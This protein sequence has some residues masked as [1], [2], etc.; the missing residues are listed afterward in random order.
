MASRI[1]AAAFL[2]ISHA[3]IWKKYKTFTHAK[4]VLFGRWPSQAMRQMFVAYQNFAPSA[5]FFRLAENERLLKLN[6]IGKKMR[7]GVA[8]QAK[9]TFGRV[10]TMKQLRNVRNGGHR[11]ASRQSTH[12]CVRGFNGLRSSADGILMRLDSLCT[13]P[14]FVKIANV[15][16]FRNIRRYQLI[17]LCLLGFPRIRERDR[18]IMP[19]LHKD[20]SYPFLIPRICLG[21]CATTIR[22][23]KC[24][25]FCNTKHSFGEKRGANQSSRL[26]WG[27]CFQNGYPRTQISSIKQHQRIGTVLSQ[28]KELIMGNLKE[29]FLWFARDLL[30]FPDDFLCRR[31]S[32]SSICN[33]RGSFQAAL[34]GPLET[35]G[36]ITVHHCHVLACF[37]QAQPMKCVLSNRTIERSTCCLRKSLPSTSHNGRVFDSLGSIGLHCRKICLYSAGTQQLSP[38]A[39]HLLRSLIYITEHFYHPLSQ[40]PLSL[41]TPPLFTSPPPNSLDT[42]DRPK[43]SFILALRIKLFSLQADH[44]DQSPSLIESV[45][46]CYPSLLETANQ[47]HSLKAL[48]PASTQPFFSSVQP[49]TALRYLMWGEPVE[50]SPEDAVE[51]AFNLGG[52]ASALVTDCTSHIIHESRLND[53]FDAVFY[54]SRYFIPLCCM[55]PPAI[56]KLVARHPHQESEGLDEFTLHGWSFPATFTTGHRSYSPKHIV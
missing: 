39:Q 16:C 2:R 40:H 10:N 18:L 30:R 49:L 32:R 53:H 41:L 52:S 50:G 37:H 7:Q 29:H 35:G 24:R 27:A 1:E 25:A 45:P 55:S 54:S 33:R 38:E 36:G 17:C 23:D 44:H 56:W 21:I 20:S 46:I 34:T 5:F 3:L 51:E 26:C 12:C 11:V 22:V 14:F 47:T 31:K 13:T 19:T 48:M 42:K 43:F 9:V 28:H 8:P 6:F 15:P 4:N